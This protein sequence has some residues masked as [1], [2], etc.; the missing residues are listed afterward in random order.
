M[1][2]ALPSKARYV[3]AEPMTAVKPGSNY[4]TDYHRK[5]VLILYTAMHW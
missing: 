2:I 3:F 5:I 4:A 1:K